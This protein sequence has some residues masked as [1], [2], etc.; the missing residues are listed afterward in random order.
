MLS[1]CSQLFWSHSQLIWSRAARYSQLMWSRNGGCYRAKPFMLSG[2]YKYLI[3][4]DT[5]RWNAD[6]TT[7]VYARLN[8]AK[9]HDLLT[10]PPGK[11]RGPQPERTPMK[12][13]SR[14][15]MAENEKPLEAPAPHLIGHRKKFEAFERDL[16]GGHHIGHLPIY[17]LI[18]K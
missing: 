17:G 4:R 5:R 10:T 1:G 8:S 2:R 7:A 14:N 9:R 13:K 6:S 3:V 15:S 18:H 12:Q 11:E 16:T